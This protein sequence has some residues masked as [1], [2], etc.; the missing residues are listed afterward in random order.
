MSW[1]IK[2]DPCRQAFNAAAASPRLPKPPGICI[3]PRPLIHV[4]TFITAACV[5]DC[6]VLFVLA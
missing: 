5:A 4:G 2:H 3:R 6:K 1:S